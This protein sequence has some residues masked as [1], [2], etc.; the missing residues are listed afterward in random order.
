MTKHDEVRQ[1]LYES[2]FAFKD[3]DRTALDMT[4][5]EVE[6]FIVAFVSQMAELGRAMRASF[7]QMIVSI[8]RAIEPMHDLSRVLA[9]VEVERR[10]I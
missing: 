4:D 10:R 6:A 7:E 9:A 3:S 8:N 2:G 5:E 1:I